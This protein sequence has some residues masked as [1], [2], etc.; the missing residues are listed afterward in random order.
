MVQQVCHVP[1]TPNRPIPA[2]ADPARINAIR[3]LEK[4]WVNGSVIKYY[5]LP[6]FALPGSPERNKAYQDVVR[7]AFSAWSDLG[8]GLTLL[9]ASS[10]ADAQVRIGFVQGD[11]SWSY[12]GRDV[13]LDL[14]ESDPRTM[15]FGWDL[16]EP[17][18]DTAIHEVGHTLG[19]QHEHQNPKSGALSAG[20]ACLRL[21]CHCEFDTAGSVSERAHLLLALSGITITHCT[22][23]TAT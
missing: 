23:G 6:E 17:G 5:F 1:P 18:D 3:L 10:K 13:L 22:M 2:S 7:T 16:T 4:K 21:V 20:G 15:N 11:G 9:E 14:P 19:L 12:V 8:L